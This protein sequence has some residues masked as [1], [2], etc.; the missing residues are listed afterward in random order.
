LSIRDP[1]RYDESIQNYLSPYPR[2]IQGDDVKNLNTRSLKKLTLKDIDHE[3]AEIFMDLG[4]QST[5]EEITLFLENTFI[6]PFLLRHEFMKRIYG[7]N[8]S[9][10]EYYDVLSE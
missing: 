1:H 3:E 2:S 9:A 4:L 5:C 10:S 7:I 8:L 6:E